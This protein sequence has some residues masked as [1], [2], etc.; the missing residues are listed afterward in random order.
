MKNF[1]IIE[2]EKLK[3]V[4]NFQFVEEG[5]YNDLNDDGGFATYRIAMAADLEDG[6]DTQY[7]LEDILDEYLVHVEEFLNNDENNSL[8]YIFGGELDDVQNFKSIIGKKVCNEEFVDE[9]GQTRVR[10]K[11]CLLYTSDA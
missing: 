11:I 1:R 3:D 5:I 6:E 9:E 8:K 4:S 2:L 7:P 10:L